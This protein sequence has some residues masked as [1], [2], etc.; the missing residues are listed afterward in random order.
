[1]SGTDRVARVTR[2]AARGPGAVSAVDSGSMPAEPDVTYLSY[3]W[4]AAVKLLSKTYA[5]LATK[6]P[7]A[8]NASQMQHPPS[9]KVMI[10][11]KSG[12]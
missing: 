3:T 1:M 10:R 5:V 2:K 11:V 9:W 6:T 4:V 12:P 8:V 7:H